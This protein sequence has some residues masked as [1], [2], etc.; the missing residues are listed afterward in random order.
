[1]SNVSFEEG[2][3][4][5]SST[6]VK[7]QGGMTERFANAT[8]VSREAAGMVLL[9]IA[10]PIIAISLFLVWKAQTASPTPTVVEIENVQ[11][12]LRPAYQ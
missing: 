8:H 7:E 5:I 10:C 12:E 2:P 9:S 1:M 4:I 6:P 3:R 11:E